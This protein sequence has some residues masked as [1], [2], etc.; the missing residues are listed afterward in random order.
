M[1]LIW[2]VLG[3]VDGAAVMRNLSQIAMTEAT[4]G[5]RQFVVGIGNSLEMGIEP[6]SIESGTGDAR[7]MVGK[8]NNLSES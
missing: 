8:P 7:A 5:S 4:Y 1:S 2:K 6:L 3:W